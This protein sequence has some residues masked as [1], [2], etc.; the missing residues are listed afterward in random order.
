M[1]NVLQQSHNLV[2]ERQPTLK[3]LQRLFSQNG[4]V[5]SGFCATKALRLSFNKFIVEVFNGQVVCELNPESLFHQYT[6]GFVQLQCFAELERG[7]KLRLE[8]LFRTFVNLI[9]NEY[10]QIQ[11]QK[12]EVLADNE[13]EWEIV[14][15]HYKD[16]P[17]P[18][19]WF[20]YYSKYM[21]WSGNIEY[22]RPDK[23]VLIKRYKTEVMKK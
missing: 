20:A 18:E 23:D 21:D 17:V 9:E 5:L 13:P 19:G 4:S 15:A 1:A 2:Y 10:C 6:C 8:T 7:E 22:D 11:E 3:T 14:K 16:E 12:Q